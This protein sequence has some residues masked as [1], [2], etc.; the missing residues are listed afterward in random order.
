MGTYLYCQLK[1][2]PVD[3]KVRIMEYA[4]AHNISRDLLKQAIGKIESSRKNYRRCCQICHLAVGKNSF[5]SWLALPKVT[6]EDFEDGVSCECCWNCVDDKGYGYVLGT[7]GCFRR[8][9]GF[10]ATYVNI[11]SFGFKAIEWSSEAS[12]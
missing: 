5:G 1:G 4:Q 12:W 10:H 7:D 3:V 9:D 8:S 11:P 6:E 2:L